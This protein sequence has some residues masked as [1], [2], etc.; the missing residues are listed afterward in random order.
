MDITL[1]YLKKNVSTPITVQ[2][3]PFEYFDEPEADDL[4]IDSVPRY[5]DPR[6]Y[7]D[8]T[9][10]LINIEIKVSDNEKKLVIEINYFDGQQS[11]VATRT[12]YERETVIYKEII[13]DMLVP[14]SVIGSVPLHR[15]ARFTIE[16]E[17]LNCIYSV[18]ISDN[19]DGT[20]TEYK[21]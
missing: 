1:K 4:D 17:T 14:P 19:D 10:G 21:I 2:L 12:E 18:I 20:Q 11:S 7:L 3:T 5:L 15:L 9:E 8:N 6:D 16:N 13:I